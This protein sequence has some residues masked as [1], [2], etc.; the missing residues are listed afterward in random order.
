MAGAGLH[1]I[2]IIIADA[3]NLFAYYDV[4]NIINLLSVKKDAYKQL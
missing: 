4:M 1:V 2:V 3:Y